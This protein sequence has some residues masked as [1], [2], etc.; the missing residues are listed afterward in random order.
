M[1][2]LFNI[3]TGGLF[4]G[5]SKQ[6]G[7]S[8]F[9]GI[10]G[11]EQYAGAQAGQEQNVGNQQALMSALS[12]FSS[13]YLGQTAPGRDAMINRANSLLA[14]NFDPTSSPMYAPMRRGVE[15][16][17][18]GARENI[19]STLPGGGVQ[20]DALANLES[21]RASSLSDI[22]GSIMSQEM[23][24]AYGVAQG[25]IPTFLQGMSGASQAGG[26]SGQMM[27]SILEFLAKRM[28]SG[29]EAAGNLSPF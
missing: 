21:N 15:S 10:P 22:M 26:L 27:G 18:G 20:Q 1:S 5:G 4:G 17:Y 29:V 16:S 25:S 11:E 24:N 3:I 7:I 8:G 14:G 2:D 13:Q 12:N 9:F 23:Q 19:L 6:S 28:A